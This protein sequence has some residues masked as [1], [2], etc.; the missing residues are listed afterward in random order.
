MTIDLTTVSPPSPPS[1]PPN[2]PQLSTLF[3]DYSIDNLDRFLICM[4]SFA[5]M[6]QVL[7]SALV[8]E[9]LDMEVDKAQ[10]GGFVIAFVKGRFLTLVMLSLI[11]PLVIAG[12]IM[13]VTIAKMATHGKD[14]YAKASI[15]VEQTTGSIRMYNKSLVDAYNTS[16]HEG[17]A[18]GL[19]LGVMMLL[20]L[21]SYALAV[22]YST[23][24]IIEK[25]YNGGTVLTVF[26]AM[27]TR[28][29]SL[30]YASPCLTAFA[31]GR[32]TAYK[33]KRNQRAKKIAAG[34]VL[35][36]KVDEVGRGETVKGK[37][38]TDDTTP[39]KKKKK[40]NK[41]K[42][43]VT[44]D[45]LS[46][47]VDEIGKGNAIE[48]LSATDITE[49]ISGNG[50]SLMPKS[51]TRMILSD[52]QDD[53]TVVMHYGEHDECDY[54]TSEE[55]V[56]ILPNNVSFL[57]DFD[58]EYKFML[59]YF[60][61]DSLKHSCI[62]GYH[63]VNIFSFSKAYGMMGWRVGCVGDGTVKGVEGVIYLW[64]KLPE[65]F[66][67]DFEVVRWLANK[68]RMYLIPG[69]PCGCSGHVRISFSGLVKKDCQQP[70]G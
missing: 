25:G 32:A 8:H 40:R 22:C 34:D 27:L 9:R 41:K 15:V 13:S 44:G 56:P 51:R 10:E 52:K 31:T 1:S 16:V 7:V 18:I 68:H 2:Y 69:T 48:G 30:G 21:C 24:M 47:K 17:L 3:L 35:S 33:R 59:Q 23:M 54:L 29:M 64:A 11:P 5:R 19:G 53:G 60:M 67:D 65:K 58:L 55:C 4:K 63:I 62:E 26:F 46:A 45:I 42:K 12:G 28:S 43:K 14:A 61:Y 50:F 49:S 6:E 36:A 70:R 38:V 66:I 57:I 39:K 37:I 20:L